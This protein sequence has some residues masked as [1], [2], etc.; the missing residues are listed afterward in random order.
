MLIYFR[1]ETVILPKAGKAGSFRVLRLYKTSLALV[2]SQGSTCKVIVHLNS[3]SDGGCGS[4]GRS[5]VQ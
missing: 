5:V 3:S 1:N 2:F 4:G